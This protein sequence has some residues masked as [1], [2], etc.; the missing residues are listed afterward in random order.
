VEIVVDVSP[1]SGGQVAVNGDVATSYPETFSL[2]QDSHDL[3]IEAI[4]AP[5]YCFV[6]WSG[7]DTLQGDGNPLELPRARN[8]DLVAVFA[9]QGQIVEYASP[10][11]VLRVAIPYGIS[12]LGAEG[13]PATNIGF[14]IVDHPPPTGNSEI[15]GYAYQI[16]PEGATFTPSVSMT[17]CYDA[18]NIPDGVAPEQLTIAYYD[19][20]HDMWMALE[21][22]LDLSTNTISTWIDHL[23]LFAMLAPT[24]GALPEHA[25]CLGQLNVRLGES[26]SD[27]PVKSITVSPD[28]PV[29]VDVLVR[30][31]WDTADSYVVALEID[32][33][34]EKQQQVTLAAGAFTTVTFETSRSEEGTYCLTI[35]GLYDEA[36]LIVTGGSPSTDREPTLFPD[37]PSNMT[38]A[39]SR[40]S[41]KALVLIS[42]GVFCTVF[43]L[44]K[45]R[46][47]R[48]WY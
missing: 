48:N 38:P 1:S 15:V 30:N 36:T 12:A 20:S 17:W 32:G 37:E 4:P 22:R 45:I 43:A 7:E 42:I 9:P 34:I 18:T 44:T 35:S 10:G 24:Q 13:M 2:K 40:P 47:N 8:L 33:A 6:G 31:I 41:P 11:G 21:S 28:E 3:L 16:E 5:G 26:T 19:E 27:E 39:G 29:Y 46:R 14:T 23:S 25:P